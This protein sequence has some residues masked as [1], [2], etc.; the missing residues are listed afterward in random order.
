[1]KGGLFSVIVLHA[2][3]GAPEPIHGYYLTKY[4]DRISEGVIHI[5]AGTL[6]P[7]LKN[8]ENHGLIKHKMVKSTEGP[9]RKVYRMTSDGK[10]ALKYLLPIM[11]DLF[12]SIGKVR[13]ADWSLV[14]MEDAHE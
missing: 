11:D 2:I 1:M 8:L 10:K 13:D 14:L 4:L 7:I 3:D 12:E 5:Q 9:K 6:Y